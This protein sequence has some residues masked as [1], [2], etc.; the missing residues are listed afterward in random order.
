MTVLHLRM[1]VFVKR[2]RFSARF[3]SLL[4]SFLL[5]SLAVAACS[6]ARSEPKPP[7][8][9]SNDSAVVLAVIA[10]E[11]IAV[12]DLPAE[13]QARLA[14][15]EF[16]HQSQRYQL[17]DAAVQNELGRRLL[18]QEAE[19]QGLSTMEL[20]SQLTEDEITVTYQDVEDWYQRNRSRLGGRELEE[21]S[22]E[23]RQ[24]LIESERSRLMEEYIAEL[25]AKEGVIR[26]LEAPR[27]D[28]N[29]ENAATLGPDDAPITLVEFSDFECPYCSV[30]MR[31]LYE[32][33]DHYG[34]ELRLVFRHFPLSI[35]PNAP[36][37]AE[38][39][40]CALEQDKFWEL[41]DLMFAEQ[42]R[43]TVPDLKEKAGRIGL[44]QAE[45]DACL[46]S[47]RFAQQVV[48]DMMEGQAFG[49]EGTPGSFINGIPLLGGAVPFETLKTAIDKELKRL[50]KD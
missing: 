29:N 18:E 41:H 2:P 6:S 27:A 47:G 12:S 21:L 37:A 44:D 5:L 49:V 1:R 42:R 28:L 19:A 22:S 43:L 24:F 33:R 15:L 13:V 26:Y 32:L 48:Q 31:T 4:A 23:I 25:E 30:Y 46:D 9:S 11:S 14:A 36:K 34:D 50:G 16:Q 35:H 20:I 40:F 7:Q 8:V 17:L 10:G 38:A 39:S 45:F 3:V